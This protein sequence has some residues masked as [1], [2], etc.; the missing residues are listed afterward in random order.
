[1]EGAELELYWPGFIHALPVIVVFVALPTWLLVL[2][3]RYT[4]LPVLKK[5]LFVPV[6]ILGPFISTLAWPLILQFSGLTFMTPDGSRPPYLW[7]ATGLL[8]DWSEYV[9][10]GLTTATVYIIHRVIT[11]KRSANE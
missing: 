5:W 1:M 11:T 4:Q 9:W 8:G 2:V 10:G 3:F 6:C 7:L